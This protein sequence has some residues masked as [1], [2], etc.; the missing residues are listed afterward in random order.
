MNQTI[1]LD[2]DSSWDGGD[3]MQGGRSAE[4]GEG[5][6]GEGVQKGERGCG[7]EEC[8]RGRG[9]GGEGV[10]K[11]ERGCRLSKFNDQPVYSTSSGILGMPLTNLSL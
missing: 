2:C 3:G 6:R 8:R 1:I 4:G 5:M 11:G 9:D 10:Q 7:G